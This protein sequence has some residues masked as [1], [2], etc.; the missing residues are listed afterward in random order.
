[1]QQTVGSTRYSLVVVTSSLSDQNTLYSAPFCVP[2]LTITPQCFI[3][4]RQ[5]KQRKQ[6]DLYDSLPQTEKDP[7]S[8]NLSQKL[9]M[10]NGQT[11]GHVYCH[12]PVVSHGWW[13]GGNI[14]RAEVFWRFVWTRLKCQSGQLANTGCCWEG[15]KL[16]TAYQVAVYCAAN[17]QKS[18]SASSHS[19][20]KW[21]QQRSDIK[22]QMAPDPPWFPEDVDGR[23]LYCVVLARWLGRSFQKKYW[24]LHSILRVQHTT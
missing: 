12:G 1:M 4:K 5:G 21:P 15:F 10:T 3:P 13:R 17:D 11:F 16:A 8:V 9:A 2:H 14:D 6:E 18:D 24:R 20:S 23:P 22:W 7:V 19:S